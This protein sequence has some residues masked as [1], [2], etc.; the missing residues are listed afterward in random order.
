M[1]GKISETQTDFQRTIRSYI[2]EDR[3]LHGNVPS[4]AESLSASIEGL[5]FTET[6][7]PVSA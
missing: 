1:E 6:V 5:S 7:T 4:G 3:T 2:S